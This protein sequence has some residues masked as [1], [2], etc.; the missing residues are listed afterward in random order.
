MVP[1]D[2]LLVLLVGLVDLIP[3]PAQPIAR[4]SGRRKNYPD[5]MFLKAL[6]IISRSRKSGMSMTR[7]DISQIE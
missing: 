2:S 1:Q 7:N 6:V 4:K 3:L 5:Q